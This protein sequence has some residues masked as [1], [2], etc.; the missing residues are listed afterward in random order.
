MG[1]KVDFAVLNLRSRK[2]ATVADLWSEP[3]PGRQASAARIGSL[4]EAQRQISEQNAWDAKE[5]RFAGRCFVQAGLP[6]SLRSIDQH[7]PFV[8]VDGNT[9][10]EILPS[11]RF[12]MPFGS[13]PRL[14]L[15]WVADEVRHHKSPRIFLGNN[16]SR[17]ME[18]LDMVPTGGRWGTIPRLRNQM[19]R[20]F[21]AAIRYRYND[22][23]NSKGILLGVQEYD[24][25][26]ARPSDPEQSDLWQSHILLTDPL[27][28]ELLIHSVPVDMRTIK[29]L[30]GSPMEIDI[31]CWL[32]YRL[33]RLEYP[34]FISYEDLRK[35]F[36][37][38]YTQQKDF[39]I[40][41]NRAL[42]IVLKQYTQARVIPDTIEK[43]SKG[44]KMFPSP[45]HVPSDRKLLQRGKPVVKA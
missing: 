39:R 21:N 20:L 29:V 35:Q 30:R 10:L 7:A 26:W 17:F 23:E 24:L 8:R 16:L 4:V 28:Q 37:A 33:H 40:N 44:W 34:L 32:T 6:H 15:L 5:V 25:W 22:A 2:T 13:I 9:S 38:S 19:E 11:P 14:I 41:L 3:R 42:W 43:G 45:S 18:E 27:Y 36:G 31:Y 1:D 12:G